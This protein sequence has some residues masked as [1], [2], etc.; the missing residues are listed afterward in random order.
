MLQKGASRDNV[1][2]TNTLL[3]PRHAFYWTMVQSMWLLRYFFGEPC[4][5]AR[6]H[7]RSKSESQA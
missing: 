7:P 3:K 5:V 6:N 4:D 1:S 2:A